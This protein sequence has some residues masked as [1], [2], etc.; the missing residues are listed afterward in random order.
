MFG[1][2]STGF[3]VGGIAGPLLFGYLLDNDLADAVL[4]A[5]VG[6]MVTTTIIVLVQERRR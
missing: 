5:T 4:W 6:F 3:N 2:V 1:L